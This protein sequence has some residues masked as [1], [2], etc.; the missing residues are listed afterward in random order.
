MEENFLCRLWKEASEEYRHM[1][2]C[3]RCKS[4]DVSPDL[5]ERS[6]FGQGTMDAFVCN[7]CGYSGTFF[8]Q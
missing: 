1:R 4:K 8:P 7:E 2:F 5:S 6:A 3:P